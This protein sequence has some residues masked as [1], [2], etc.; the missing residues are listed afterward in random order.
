MTYLFFQVH[1]KFCDAMKIFVGDKLIGDGKATFQHR[2]HICIENL[3]RDKSMKNPP[4][5][6]TK[7]GK[8]TVGI[9]I[10]QYLPRLT[11]ADHTSQ[12]GIRDHLQNYHNLDDRLWRWNEI[13]ADME[14]T[15]ELQR[16]DIHKAKSAVEAHAAAAAAAENK[17]NNADIDE[18]DFMN[19]DDPLP[20]P[21]LKVV[22]GKW[23]FLFQIPGLR[24]HHQRLTG[25]NIHKEML[26]FCEKHLEFAYLFMTSGSKAN[27]ENLAFRLRLEGKSEEIS[28]SSK[29]L[30][31]VLMVA[32]H[33]EEDASLF[34]LSAEVYNY[35]NH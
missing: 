7:K 10:D 23:P 30:A 17:E 27:V 6:N 28:T 31:F 32:K 26:Q 19:D 24:N 18:P 1:A 22:K 11:E 4:T 16:E 14:A 12:A 33:F 20:E 8:G 3:M 9:L 29:L 34:I 13:N 2:F 15:Y 21:A 35:L 25:R 5:I